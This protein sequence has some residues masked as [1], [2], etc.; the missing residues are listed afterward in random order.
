MIPAQLNLIVPIFVQ[1]SNCYKL[2]SLSD[3]TYTPPSTMIKPYDDINAIIDM[4][5]KRHIQNPSVFN[6]KLTDIIVE[7][8]LHIYFLC[9]IN[10]DAIL[11]DCFLINLNSNYEYNPPNAKKTL[12]LLAR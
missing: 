7:D 3:I 4:L 1:S 10:Y 6:P 11:S 5:I 2:L 12:S 9:F 8:I